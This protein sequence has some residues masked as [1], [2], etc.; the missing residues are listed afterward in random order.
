MKTYIADHALLPQGWAEHVR[1]SVD[2][3]GIISAVTGGAGKGSPG[4]AAASGSGQ[5]LAG[6]VIAG[7][8]N[9]HSHAFQRAMAGLTEV[10]DNP[11]DIVYRVRGNRIS[12][13]AAPR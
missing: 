8:P 11:E 7:M 5:R 9:L 4:A 2:D 12:A 1:I 10:A 6:P 3:N 13:V